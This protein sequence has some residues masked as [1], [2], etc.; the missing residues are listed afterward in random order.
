MG[1]E[2]SPHDRAQEP[3]LRAE[4]HASLAPAVYSASPEDARRRRY[5]LTYLLRLCL[6]G[7]LIAVYMV[8]VLR[9]I[10]DT[11]NSCA[12]SWSAEAERKCYADNR[13]F[14]VAAF[15]F[16][17]ILAAFPICQLFGW[18][19]VKK[20]RHRRRVLVINIVG[21]VLSFFGTIW[22]ALSLY[23]VVTTIATWGMGGLYA[24]RDTLYAF[25]MTVTPLIEFVLSIIFVRYAVRMGTTVKLIPNPYQP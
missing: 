11:L 5:A 23:I 25:I 4:P 8:G 10:M 13:I 14:L 24:L 7:A 20:E 21:I 3:G 22:G 9:V 17:A 19:A 12:A 18:L 2:P 1:V 6:V 16:L 15:T